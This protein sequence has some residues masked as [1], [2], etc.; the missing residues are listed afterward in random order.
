MSLS[1]PRRL[2]WG[3]FLTSAP[4]GDMLLTSGPGRFTTG[5]ALRYQLNKGLGGTESW[6]G[7]FAKDKNDFP[8][9]KLKTQFLRRPAR[10]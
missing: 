7:R 2:T 8:Q 9:G 3:A 5:K 10:G 6:S 4:N 1:A